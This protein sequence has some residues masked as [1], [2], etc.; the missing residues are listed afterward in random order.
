VPIRPTGIDNRWG[1]ALC[2]DTFDIALAWPEETTVRIDILAIGSHGDVRPNVALG[3]GLSDAGH[4]VRVVTLDGFDELVRTCG[5]EHLSIGRSPRD[6]ATTV[7]GRGW[8]EHRDSAIGFLRGLIRVAG[9]L[10]ESGIASYWPTCGDVEALIVTPM[11]LS[12]GMH[13]AERLHIPLIRV[14]FAPTRHDWAGRSDAVTAMRGDVARLVWAGFRFLLWNGLR[15][16]TNTARRELLGLPPLPV[17]EPFSALDRQGVPTFDAYSPAVVPAPPDSRQALHVTGYWFLDDAPGW[18]PPPSLVDFLGCG[19]QPVFVGFGSTPFPNPEA[20]TEV[21]IGALTRA[22]QR[23]VVVA[24]GSGLPTGRLT[25]DI[26]GV[27]AVPHNWLFSRVVAA[28]HH[29]GAGVTGAALRAD[30]PSVVVPVFGDQP[31]WGKRVFDLG[32]GSRPL[33]AKRLTCEALAEAICRVTSDAG[34]RRRAASIG[35]QIR[36][37]DGVARAIEAFHGYVGH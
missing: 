33:P 1:T 15:R 5:L 14:S 20:A 23:G 27:D 26:V 30:L 31:F 4:R 34:I 22:R 35:R 19:S 7:E 21:V 16:R 36:A 37:E 28:V 32:A 18:V 24:G 29:G 12:V 9:S 10:I 2:A 3:L 17:T 8:I 13:I 6:I 11:G 25:D